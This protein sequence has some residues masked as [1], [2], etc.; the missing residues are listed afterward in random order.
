MAWQSPHPRRRRSAACT[1]ARKLERLLPPAAAHV[2]IV[3]D[4]N[5]ML[6]RRCCPA[7]AAGGTLDPRHIVVPLREELRRPI[8]ASAASTGAGHPR[9]RTDRGQ[10]R[11]RGPCGPLCPTTSSWSRS[12]RRR[13]RC[14]SPAFAEHA[15]GFKTLAEAIALRNR[16]ISHA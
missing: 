16:L 8:H 12:A 10:T 9:P 7:P 1:R 13:A 3:N 14:R 11:R 4:V 2:T 6:Y 15:V 5:F